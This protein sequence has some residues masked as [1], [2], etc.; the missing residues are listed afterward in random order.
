M[1]VVGDRRVSGAERVGWVLSS[2]R[3]TIESVLVGDGWSSGSVDVVPLMEKWTDLLRQVLSS[4]D[5]LCGI[6]RRR[7]GSI[8]NIARERQWLWS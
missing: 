5:L 4:G 1:V 7:Y 3:L 2:H 8:S 6:R